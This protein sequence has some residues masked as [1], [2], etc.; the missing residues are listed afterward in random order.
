MTA[1]ARTGQRWTYYEIDPAVLK[2]AQDTNYFT[3]LARAAAPVR[4][5]AGDARLRLQEAADGEYHLLVLDAFSSDA[6]PMHLI[7]REAL[8][9]YLKKLSPGGLLAFH[10]SNR[11]LGLEP[12]LANLARAVGLVA[13]N[14]DDQSL[15]EAEFATGRERSQWVVMARHASEL[16][17]F[18]RRHR[19]FRAETDPTVGIWTDEFSSPLKV[20]LW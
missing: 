3:Y 14:G 8:E 10:I 7:T 2:L 20:F 9:L 1:Y 15:G 5:V 19:W 6:I 13:M 18:Q 17:P 16:E 11:Y 4:W 12:V